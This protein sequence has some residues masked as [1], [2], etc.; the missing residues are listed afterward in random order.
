MTIDPVV[1][2]YSDDIHTIL[3]PYTVLTPYSMYCCT[4]PGPAQVL[5][6]HG[7]G[8]DSRPSALTNILP[9]HAMR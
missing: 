1:T 9:L 2:P 8:G 3:T 5:S 7:E 6:H 4:L